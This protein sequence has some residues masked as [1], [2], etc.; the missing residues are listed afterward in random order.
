MK[1]QRFFLS[2]WDLD[3]LPHMVLY[4]RDVTEYQSFQDI[5]TTFLTLRN[6]SKELSESKRAGKTEGVPLKQLVDIFQ[7]HSCIFFRCVLKIGSGFM[8]HLG[9][10][11]NHVAGITRDQLTK[12]PISMENEREISVLF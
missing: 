1:N 8:K 12:R 10:R 9:C 3:R 11:H 6:N 4:V 7:Q 5:P 2:I